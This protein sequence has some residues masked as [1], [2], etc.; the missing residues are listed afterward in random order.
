VNVAS[1][2][3]PLA[4]AAMR[5]QGG[6]DRRWARAALR[7]ALV[8][9]FAG[10]VLL[11]TAAGAQARACDPQRQAVSGRYVVVTS[12]EN[13]TCAEAHAY[14]RRETTVLRSTRRFYIGRFQC[15]RTAPVTAIG[16]SAC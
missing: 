7:A 10:S 14:V 6:D 15:T 13:M 16:P 11:A 9:T 3:A 12:A 1:P 5:T 4:F 8:A 2:G